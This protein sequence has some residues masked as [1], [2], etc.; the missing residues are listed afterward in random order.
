M[1]KLFIKFLFYF[2]KNKIIKKG[3]II[4]N[5]LIKLNFYYIIIVF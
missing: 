4:L 5:L 2:N 1:F 3:K